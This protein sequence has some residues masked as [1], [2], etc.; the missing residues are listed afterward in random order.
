MQSGRV[1]SIMYKP[2][3]IDQ[4][5]ENH[6]ARVATQSANLIAEFGIEGDEK[7]G[8]PDRQI[9]I[10]SQESLDS[11][12]SEDFKVQPGELGEQLIVAGLVVD[13]LEPGNIIQLGDNAQLRMVEPRTGCTRF[14]R[15]QGIHPSQAKGRL[16][17][18]AQV[19]TSGTIQ[20]GDSV[21][22][23]S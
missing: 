14:Q 13:D 21:T 6:F 8:H 2:S 4:K 16:G 20:I 23:I 1:V 3:E 7:G 11:L 22:L 15:I 17:M 9:N 12:A 5:P 18:M 10:M 19:A